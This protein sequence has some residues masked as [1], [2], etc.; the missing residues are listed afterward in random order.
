M[1]ALLSG[2]Q[3]RDTMLTLLFVFLLGMISIA[4]AEAAELNLYVQPIESVAKTEHAFQPLADYLSKKIGY[5]VHVRTAANFLA[6]WELMRRGK[7]FD[8][9]LDAAHF[10]DYRDQQQGY[11]VLAK[12]P[13]TVSFSL[14]TAGNLLLFDAS[15]LI[16][17]TLA[18]APSPSLAGV[19]LAQ[20]Y[21]NPLRQPTLVQ[22]SNFEQA[23]DMLKQGKIK[24]ALVPTPMVNNDNSVNT[25]MTTRP[26]P[27]MAFSVS[28]QIDAATRKKIR[29]A[30]LNANKSKP[31]KVMLQKLRYTRFQPANNAMYKGYENLL[32]GVWGFTPSHHVADNR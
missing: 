18:S 30:L 2:G 20:I 4:R 23:L 7:G 14:V 21:P 13:D 3:R 19:R 9:V 8:M 26:V 25:V 16:G 10:T 22:A 27:H 28:P 24:A 31:G 17:K 32:D 12:V 11:K 1:H 29:D 6:Y 5:T 15:E